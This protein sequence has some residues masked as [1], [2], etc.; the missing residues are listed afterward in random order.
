MVT[1]KAQNMVTRNAQIYII[2]I[3]M[4]IEHRTRLEFANMDG[5]Q[6]LHQKK[7]PFIVIKN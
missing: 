2:L 5:I 6:G 4:L 3:Y 1:R 7:I